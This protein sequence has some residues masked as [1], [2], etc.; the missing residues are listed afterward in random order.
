MT[1][2]NVNMKF[3]KATFIAEIWALSIPLL[4]TNLINMP[5]NSIKLI[6]VGP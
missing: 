3:I 4:Y 5:F 2:T 6:K 1:K